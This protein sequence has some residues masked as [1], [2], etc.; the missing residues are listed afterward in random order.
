MSYI[1]IYSNVHMKQIQNIDF[2]YRERGSI[3]A[4]LAKPNKTFI[5]GL[6]KF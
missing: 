6:Q 1:Y 5:L 4:G 3:S 2:Q